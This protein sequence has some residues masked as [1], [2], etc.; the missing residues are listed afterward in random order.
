M[1]DVYKNNALKLKVLRV[2][3]NQENAVLLEASERA[4]NAVAS[5]VASAVMVLRGGRPTATVS[6]GVKS[7]PSL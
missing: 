2:A 4:K 5:K 3:L 6:I 7:R 1:T